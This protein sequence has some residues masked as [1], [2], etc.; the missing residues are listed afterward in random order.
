MLADFVELYW[1]IADAAAAWLRA[2][3]RLQGLESE[4]FPMSWA[5][6]GMAGSSNEI[7]TELIR[8]AVRKGPFGAEKRPIWQYKI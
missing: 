6:C 2:F 8:T 3:L 5:G 7:P 1:R 4:A